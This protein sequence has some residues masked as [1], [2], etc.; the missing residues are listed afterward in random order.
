[1]LEKKC[2]TCYWENRSWEKC[3][4]DGGDCFDDKDGQKRNWKPY[5]HGD[6]IRNM[7]DEELG[8]MIFRM[9]EIAMQWDRERM[10]TWLESQV[11]EK[12]GFWG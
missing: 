7:P 1:M 2:E 9:T 12:R 8:E 3:F 5:T 11:S 4:S 6:A 10:Q